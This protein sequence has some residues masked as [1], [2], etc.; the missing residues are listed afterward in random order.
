M[1][2]IDY[3]TIKECITEIDESIALITTLDDS[4]IGEALDK[5]IDVK[6]VLYRSLND[7][8]ETLESMEEYY[9]E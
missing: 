2:V 1:I 4:E 7:F 8:E 3:G 9:E 6:A 5:L